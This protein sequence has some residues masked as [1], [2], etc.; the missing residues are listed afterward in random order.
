MKE[1]RKEAKS[2]TVLELA[3]IKLMEGA[4]WACLNTAQPMHEEEANFS[5]ICYPLPT[6]RLLDTNAHLLE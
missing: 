4:V 5:D 1:R 6:P 2:G 3:A